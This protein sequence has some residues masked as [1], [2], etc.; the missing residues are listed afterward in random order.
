MKRYVEASRILVRLSLSVFSAFTVAATAAPAIAQ[1]AA[2]SPANTT[3]YVILSQNKVAGK[4]IVQRLTRCGKLKV[5]FTYRDNGR[6]PDLF[7]D[8]TVGPTGQIES[9]VATGKSTFRCAYR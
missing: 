4:Q 3:Q 2:A 6:G 1:V 9:F 8:I 5:E 7:E